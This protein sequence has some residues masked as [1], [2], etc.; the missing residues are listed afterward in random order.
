MATTSLGRLTLDLAVRLSEFTD[1]LSRA[2]RETQDRTRQMGDSVSNFRQRVMDELGG[3]PIGGVIDSL[4][5]RF[6]SLAGGGLAV[7]GALAGM[8]VGGVAVAAG[9]LTALALETAKADVELQV[10]A[11]TAN[12][13]LKSF[14]VLTYAAAQ[15]GVEQDALAGILADTQE[16]LGEF[17][18]TGGGG[19]ADFFEALQNNTEMTD[20]QIRELGKTLQG[21]D[22][23][24][25]IQLVKDKMDALGATS[26]E[27]R[28]VFESLAGDLGNLMPLFADGGKILNEYGKELEDA[29]VIKTKESIEQSRR[30]TAQTQAIQT[31]FDG[32]KTQLAVQMM[33]VLNDLI[34]YFVKG[35]SKGGKFGSTMES[36]GLIARTVGAG[37]ISVA[38]GVKLLVRMIQAFGE[39]VANIGITTDNFL[40]AD[41][42]MAKARALKTGAGAVYDINAR[43]GVET[44]GIL[45]DAKD[46]ITGMFKPAQEE[47]TGLA[48]A[49]YKTNGELDRSTS[50]MRTNTV[51]AEANAKAKEEAAKAEEKLAKARSKTSDPSKYIQYANQGATR[52]RKLNSELEQA[53][54]FLQEEGIVFKVTSGGQGAKGSGASRVG[55]TAHDHGYAADGDLYKG[56]KKLDW[57]NSKDLP[58]LKAL[59]EEAAARG[60]NGIGAANDYMGAGRF[61]FGIQK[62]AAAW[63]K[64]GKSANAL[65][66]VKAA[67][68]AGMQRKGSSTFYG[69]ALAAEAK[70]Q[71]QA[72]KE[73]LRLK[74]EIERRKMSIVDRYAS[75][76]EKIEADHAKAVIAIE[77]AYVEGSAERT[78]YLAREEERYLK[79]KNAGKNSIM[80]RYMDEEERMEREHQLKIQQIKTEFVEGDPNRQKYIDLQNAAYKEDLKNFKWAQGQKTREQNDRAIQLNDLISMSNSQTLAAIEDRSAQ[81][82]MRPNEYAVWRLEKDYE[83]GVGTMDSVYRS[84][85]GEINATTRDG[86]YLLPEDSRNRLLEEA[87]EEHLNK[88]MLLEKDHE[89]KQVALSEQLAAKRAA[90]NSSLFSD[91]TSAAAAFFG[92]NSRM[93]KIAF[94]MERAY[95]VQKAVMNIETTRSNTFDAL[96]AIPVIGPYIAGPGSIAAAV[97]QVATAANIKGMSAPSVAGIAHGGLDNVPKESTYFLDKGE[98]VLS[99]R[100]NTDLTKYLSQGGKARTGDITINNNSSAEVSAR[101]NDDG[102][103][104]IEMV[105]KMIKRSFGRIADSNSFESK[106]IQR[107]T[108]ARVKR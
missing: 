39:Q 103:V 45:A 57:N 62:N 36:V 31:R 93:H 5:D 46:A 27:Q 69:K 101:R 14:Q 19:A 70:E 83:V 108:T 64:D 95:A 104:S 71:E 98:R 66:W 17:S 88:M 21:K 81:L 30:L 58:L 32:F 54:S 67:H 107:H 75:E 60:I 28:F 94:A 68:S 29:G 23:A 78:E 102:S 65:G 44:V 25:A 8:A 53:L 87:R 72:D 82:T 12:T 22:G 26:Q 35:D 100:Q 37:I 85:Q 42:F 34:G 55:S 10:M 43:L 33:P 76:R 1:G 90:I 4:N 63:G 92:E 40:N 41:G 50:G 84:R 7:G 96:S 2:E 59:V 91:M 73:A 24:E 105:D 52:N 56:G 13:S 11:N 3:T 48:G 86:E 38:T 47:L 49:L 15:L 16:K 61:H 9:A 99:P 18:A 79:E 77:T 97:L 74:E 51:E 80:S 6:G 89:I 106:Q 20:E